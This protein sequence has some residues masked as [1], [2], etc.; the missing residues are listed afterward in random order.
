M[1]AIAIR[2]NRLSDPVLKAVII[3]DDFDSATGA[4]GLLERVAARADEAVKWD[5]KPWRFDVLK[6]PTLAALTVAVAAN[7]DLVVLALNR[8]HS[9]SAELLDWLKHWAEHRRVGMPP[10][11][12]CIPA[13]PRR[14]PRRK[15]N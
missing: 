8:F 1:T 14:G 3:Y 2:N 12:R 4:I 13:Q 9:T 7:A 5:F 10:C 11:W 6:Q 15:T